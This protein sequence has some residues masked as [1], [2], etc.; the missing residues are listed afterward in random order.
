MRT[1]T[2]TRSIYAA[3]LALALPFGLAACGG[4]E[5]PSKDEVRDG[6]AVMLD[7]QLSAMGVT[8]DQIE[9]AG[10]GPALDDY[11][12]C[13]VDGVYDDVSADT[14]Q[15]IADGDPEAQV[16]DGDLQTLTDA[17]ESCVAS[18]LEPAMP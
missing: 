12:S 3:G 13:V 7:Q 8:A 1:A 17:S 9:A 15:K 18:E 16:A 14:L 6:V 2:K 4:D 5:K 11:Y 10:L